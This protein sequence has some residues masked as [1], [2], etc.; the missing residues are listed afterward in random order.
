MTLTAHRGE[1]V[2]LLGDPRGRPDALRHYP[3]GLLVLEDGH[4]RALGPFEDTVSTLPDE[5]HVTLHERGLIVPGFVD[6]HVHYPQLDMMAAPGAKLMDWL[7]RYTFPAEAAFADADHAQDVAGRF[8]A[9]LLAHG[10]TTALVFATVHAQSVDALFAA[11]LAEN[12]R[13]IGGKVLMDRNAPD[14]LCEDADTAWRDSR[15]LIARWR[16]CGRLGYAVTPRFAP[17]CSPE[18]LQVAGRLLT[19][20]PDA[21]LQT[22]LAENED[23]IALVA[24]LFPEA[25]DYLDVYARHDLLTDRS[26]FAH[27]VHADD[28]M[29]SRLAGAD[30]AIATCP[31][32]NMFL[33][34]G[35]F[36][37]DTARAAGIRIGLGSDVGAGTTLSIPATAGAAYQ[38]GHLRGSALDP[39]EAFYMMTLGGASALRLADRIGNFTPGKEADFLVLDAAATPVLARRLAGC[40][41]IAEMLFAMTILG[42]DR[43]V[44]HTYVAGRLAYTARA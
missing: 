34:S 3:D 30:A 6:C 24:Q 40:R 43:I 12:M 14:A 37:Y 5:T 31:T 15:D 41:D 23:E 11:A 8:I 1:I 39:L 42:D 7:E 2:D 29:R 18:L 13:L 36:D 38:A 32:S 16:G 35:L 10:T 33:G 22:H 19:E 26:V 25:A 20:T 27:C 9:A 28:A 44:R 4:V 21:L 17:G